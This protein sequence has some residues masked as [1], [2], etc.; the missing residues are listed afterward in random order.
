MSVLNFFRFSHW[1][2]IMRHSMAERVIYSAVFG[3]DFM[4]FLK[5]L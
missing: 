3:K 4:E 5:W 2:G 1:I